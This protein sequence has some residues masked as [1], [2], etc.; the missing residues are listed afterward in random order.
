MQKSIKEGMHQHSKG[1][2]YF[3]R[4]TYW[5]DTEIY[6]LK[7]TTGGQ[8]LQTTVQTTRTTTTSEHNAHFMTLFRAK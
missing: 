3:D 6:L 8:T 5:T 1:N 7:S 2:M 4:L